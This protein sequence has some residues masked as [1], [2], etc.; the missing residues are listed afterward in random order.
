MKIVQAKIIVED[1]SPQ[2]NL[3]LNEWLIQQRIKRE[4]IVSTDFDC[5]GGGKR[6]LVFYEVEYVEEKEAE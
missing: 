6:V 4:N 2:L 3:K 5:C 1:S